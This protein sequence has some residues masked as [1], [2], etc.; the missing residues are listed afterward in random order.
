MADARCASAG[1]RV[2]LGVDVGSSSTKGALVTLDGR[3][4]AVAERRH[5]LR[6]LAPGR[7]EHD[8]SEWWREFASVSRELLKGRAVQLEAVSVS[9]LG[10]CLLPA[11][12]DGRPVRAAIS[13][14]VDTR[15]TEQIAELYRS[16][17]ISRIDEVCGHAL[18]SQSVGPKMLW[19][20]DNEP[21]VWARTRTFFT[22]GSYLV[23]RLTGRYVLDHTTA[24]MC[25]PFYD[26]RANAWDDQWVREL[27]PEI[28]FPE[29]RWPDQIIG[30][31]LPG[32]SGE[33]G[34]PTGTPVAAGTMDFWAENIGCGAERPGDCMIAYGTTMSVSAVTSKVISSPALW[35]APGSAA[36]IN[37]VG[38]ATSTAGALTDWM[39]QLTS[40]PEYATLLSEAERVP[41]GSRGLLVLPYFSGE[42]SPIHDPDARG[43]MVGLSL[44]H[45][46]GEMYRAVLEAIA[47]SV[48]H[49]LSVVDAAGVGV[50]RVVA[51]G[52]GVRGP[53]WARIVSDVIGRPQQVPSV[54]LGAAYGDALVAARGA[55]VAQTGR[56][57]HVERE[58][59]PDP[60][61]AALYDE[62]F[63]LYRQ[64]D[65]ATRTIAHTLSKV[66]RRPT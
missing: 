29:L 55:G 1:S 46:R 28:R 13:Y 51:V 48:R 18:T 64:L 6:S 66:S 45:G 56:W 60:R 22:S 20:R 15:A 44:S 2:T 3:V 21:E 12:G 63:V 34:I 10:P 39:R 65:E 61:T 5:E 58:I 36:D 52:G 40:T 31:V 35:S 24:S 16:Y 47:L 19:L 32:V 42:R 30:S 8:S 11:D 33:T 62:L 14:G 59:E 9:G 50:D 54:P 43:V 4:V 41:A 7:V 57:G 37:H 53:L 49:V 38:G 17:P 27:A 25:D 26:A 23:H